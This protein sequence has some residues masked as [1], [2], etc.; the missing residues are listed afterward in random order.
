MFMAFIF[1]IQA[2]LYCER[3]AQNYS[4]NYKKMQYV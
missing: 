3:I 2:K 1:E 4:T